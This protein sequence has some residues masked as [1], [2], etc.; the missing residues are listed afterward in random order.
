[1]PWKWWWIGSWSLSPA[2]GTSCLELFVFSYKTFCYH[3][4]LCVCYLLNFLIIRDNIDKK[5]EWSSKLSLVTAR[6]H[7]FHTLG[8]YHTVTRCFIDSFSLF[9][10]RSLSPIFSPHPPHPRHLRQA[11]KPAQ[12]DKRRQLIVRHITQSAASV[13]SDMPAIYYSRPPVRHA[14][15]TAL[16]SV[17]RPE[18]MTSHGFRIQ[19]AA[20]VW[21]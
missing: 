8:V 13:V 20:F 18:F 3:H 5:K 1:V 2:Y 17:F 15:R 4:H 11:L 7:L 6:S 10:C 19:P 12:R 9:S 16:L 21:M 14:T